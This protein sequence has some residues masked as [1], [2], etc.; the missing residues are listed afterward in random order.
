MVDL[1][2]DEYGLRIERVDGHDEPIVNRKYL[3]KWLAM[4]ILTGLKHPNSQKQLELRPGLN[5]AL[6]NWMLSAKCI[7]KKGNIE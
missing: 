2:S 3:N 5:A 4:D 1:Y 7:V 6:R